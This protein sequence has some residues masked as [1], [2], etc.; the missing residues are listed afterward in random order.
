MVSPMTPKRAPARGFTLIE[1]MI[2][3]AIVALLAA[4]A[5]P[6]YQD[7]IWKGK[8]GE[9]KTALLKALQA[10][11]RY[12][13][14]NNAY[15]AYTTPAPSGAFPTFSAD[16]A[17]NSRYTVAAVQGP[18]TAYLNTTSVTL[19]PSPNNAVSQC[20][21]IRATVNGTADPNCGTTLY[22][23][24]IGNKASGISDPKGICWR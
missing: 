24:S 5:I 16:N 20:I 12:Y 7:S 9:A 8:R 23:D 10:E 13:T 15:I 22:M 21:V 19:C 4:I 14:Q 2:T 1:L 17:A 18:V 3:V 11:E 6:S